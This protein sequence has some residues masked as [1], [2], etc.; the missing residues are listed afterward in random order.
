MVGTMKIDG[1]K[2]HLTAWKN[3][4]RTGE[5]FLSLSAKP[6]PGNQDER[7]PRQDQRRARSVN[8]LQACI[9]RLKSLWREPEDKPQ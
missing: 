6:W 5:L 7:T 1:R 2:Y 4:T 8:C 3:R 9:A